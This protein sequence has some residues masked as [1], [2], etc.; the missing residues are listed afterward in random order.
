[1]TQRLGGQVGISMLSEGP[2]SRVRLH[3]FKNIHTC[4]VPLQPRQSMVPE[5]QKNPT[6]SFEVHPLPALSFK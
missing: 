4:V 2:L 1:M 6:R 3:D 5:L